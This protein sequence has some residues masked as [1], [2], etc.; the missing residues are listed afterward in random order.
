MTN[1]RGFERIVEYIEWSRNTEGIEA[2]YDQW[3]IL[4]PSFNLLGPSLVAMEMMARDIERSGDGTGFRVNP[5]AKGRAIPTPTD[6]GMRYFHALTRFQRFCAFAGR[7]AF[8]PHVEA[9]REA[10][11]VLDLWPDTFTFSKRGTYETGLCKTH[12]QVFNEVIAKTGEIIRSL[13]FE[14]HLRRRSSNARQNEAM[15]LAIEQQVFATEPQ[16]VVLQLTLGYQVQHR[17]LIRPGEIQTHREA[18]LDLCRTD[19]RLSRVV[20][21]YI[22]TQGEGA[23]TG[24]HLQTMVFFSAEAHRSYHVPAL[25]GESWMAVTG[26]K[27]QY[28][29]DNALGTFCEKYRLPVCVGMIDRHDDKKREALRTYIHYMTHADQYLFMPRFEDCIVFGTSAIREEMKQ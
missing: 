11:M 22:W 24:L 5:D 25:L 9:V 27:G 8:S 14:R 6:F 21:D 4:L 26:G 19:M 20:R 1:E 13:A 28:W 12:A 23:E 16:S 29:H 18:L 10:L 15:A 3:A 7:Y 17:S 2:E